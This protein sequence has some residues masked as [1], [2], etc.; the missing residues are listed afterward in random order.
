LFGIVPKMRGKIQVKTDGEVSPPHTPP[1][2]GVLDKMSSNRTVNIHQNNHLT[3]GCFVIK[4]P[5][6]KSWVVGWRRVR[7]VQLSGSKM[8]MSSRCLA[9]R[10][11]S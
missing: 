9:R 11:Y 4:N 3:D 8:T 5:R 10:S 1:S 6:P 7:R 2:L